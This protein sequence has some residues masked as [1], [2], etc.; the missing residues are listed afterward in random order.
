MKN[1]NFVYSFF[2]LKLFVGKEFD[3]QFLVAGK[4]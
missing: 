1:L 2:Y 4:R 3:I